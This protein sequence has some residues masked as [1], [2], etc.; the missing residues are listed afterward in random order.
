MELE[1]YFRVC[2][3]QCRRCGT[4]IE[5]RSKTKTDGGPDRTIYC[6]C[7]GVGMSPSAY[8]RRIVIVPPATIWDV[9]ELS[10]KWEE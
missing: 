3:V 7:G 4:I 1:H 5:W 6:Q 2:R 8:A 9:E 10:E